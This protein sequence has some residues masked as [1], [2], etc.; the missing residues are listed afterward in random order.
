MSSSAGNRQAADQPPSGASVNSQA[1]PEGGQAGADQSSRTATA[2]DHA[3]AGPSGTDQPPGHT[4][5]AG[6]T[7][8]RGEPDRQAEDRQPAGRESATSGQR[9]Q[10]AGDTQTEGTRG[11]AG[12]RSTTPNR[13]QQA[14]AGAAQSTASSG[15][16]SQAT[17]TGGQ[18]GSRAGDRPTDTATASQ[19]SAGRGGTGLS[20]GNEEALKA[21]IQTLLKELSGELKQLEAQLAQ[22]NDQ[23]RPEAGS[24]TDPA[25]YESSAPM[26][27]SGGSTLPIGVQTDTVKT[28]ASRPGG[29]VG[30]PAGSA[31][32]ASP[33]VQ[34]EEAQLSEAPLEETPAAR[35]V[36]PPEYRSVFERLG[37]ERP[38]PSET[39]P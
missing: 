3:G 37:R 30:R 13:P 34:A 31:A 29:G 32:A 14:N 8:A 6:S 22:A 5:Q 24:S 9:A 19:Q 26:G 7:P 35:Q 12:R 36:V 33:G 15:T 21:D 16:P 11:S 18:E 39:K 27:P 38:Q 20:S 23:A 28:A 17:S 25:L 2:R 10:S 4:Q 1:G